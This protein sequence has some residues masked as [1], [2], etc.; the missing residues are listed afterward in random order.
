[1]DWI[2]ACDVKYVACGPN[3]TLLLNN[4]G[5]LYSCGSND[6]GQL[7]HERPRKRPRMSKFRMW[8]KTLF[9]N[10]SHFLD[11]YTLQE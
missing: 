2:E 10:S 11:H 5:Q 8:D 3:H 1:M 6:F 7:G 4:S 9:S